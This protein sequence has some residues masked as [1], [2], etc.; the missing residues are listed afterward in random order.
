MAYMAQ[1]RV[2]KHGGRQAAQMGTHTVACVAMRGDPRGVRRVGI[3]G[4]GSLQLRLCAGA[5]AHA[6]L[7][8]C[9]CQISRYGQALPR[10][11]EGRIAA[12]AVM[13]LGHISTLH[14]SSAF[15][16]RL[17]TWETHEVKNNGN[18]VQVVTDQS[19]AVWFARSFGSAGRMALQVALS[20]GPWGV[21][22]GSIYMGAA[23]QSCLFDNQS[24]AAAESQSRVLQHSRCYKTETPG[25]SWF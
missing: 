11:R 15:T 1:L 25:T 12:Q 19:F 7:R 24:S 10:V 4:M 6:A 16:S 5:Q 18:S 9:L 8:A 17:S 21:A 22:Q 23:T 13:C 3:S 20:Q 14:V 2:V